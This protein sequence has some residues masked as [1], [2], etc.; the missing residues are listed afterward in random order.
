VLRKEPY[1]A[2]YLDPVAALGNGND[3]NGRGHICG[4]EE[5]YIRLVI[6]EILIDAPE[7]VLG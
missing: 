7:G 4:T 3:P 1:F 2:G 6:R 5:R